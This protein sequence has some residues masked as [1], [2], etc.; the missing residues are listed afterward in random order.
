[1][2]AGEI[3]KK[4]IEFGKAFKDRKI[5]QQIDDIVDELR[6]LKQS[7]SELEDENHEFREKLRFK[8]DD[9]DFRT[10]FHYAKAHPNQPLCPKCFAKK[11]DAPM[12]EP[13]H[14]C[15]PNYRRCLVCDDC[16]K[17]SD[18]PPPGRY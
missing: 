8:S 14:E 18:S 13:G 15:A 9:Y 6:E 7:A 3:S 12:G 11:C 1:M 4:L 16:V 10:P 5:Q 2:T 17:V